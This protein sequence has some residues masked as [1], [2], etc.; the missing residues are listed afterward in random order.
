MQVNST[1]V[2]NSTLY[3]YTVGKGSRLSVLLSNNDI[4]QATNLANEVLSM[5]SSNSVLNM[6][7]QDKIKVRYIPGV[8]TIPSYM[9]HIIFSQKDMHNIHIKYVQ[10]LYSMNS[11]GLPGTRDV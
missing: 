8:Q 4:K 1:V 5:I 10:C 6:T 3:R 7:S 9:I 11:K 2:E